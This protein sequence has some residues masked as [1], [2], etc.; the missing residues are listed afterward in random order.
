MDFRDIK[1][2]NLLQLS[3]ESTPSIKIMLPLQVV[4]HYSCTTPLFF[5]LPLTLHSSSGSVFSMILNCFFDRLNLIASS[6][7]VF[8]PLF[9]FFYLF[10]YFC[11]TLHNSLSSHLSGST[12]SC[13]SRLTFIAADF[14]LSGCVNIHTQLILT[15]FELAF[16]ILRPA[17]LALTSH[18]WLKQE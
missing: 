9:S 8:L 14:K 17:L 13:R 11:T 12:S 18:L 7:C 10:I 3:K 1:K 15:L 2:T 4:I 6:P 5:R 16:K